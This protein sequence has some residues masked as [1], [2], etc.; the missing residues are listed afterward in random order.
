LTLSL[1]LVNLSGDL[2]ARVPHAL[3]EIGGRDVF[4]ID[5]G[6]RLLLLDHTLVQKAVT[7]ESNRHDDYHR[8]A[9]EQQTLLTSFAFGAGEMLTGH[10]S[11]KPD[12]ARFTHPNTSTDRQK[13]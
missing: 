11:R 1:E 9:D 5:L 8:D 3:L 13:A 12:F 4:A 10:F 7:D 2:R 6:H